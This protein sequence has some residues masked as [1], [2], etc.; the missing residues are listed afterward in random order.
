VDQI[1]TVQP[2]KCR[3]GK[4]QKGLVMEQFKSFH[5]F[6]GDVWHG[7]HPCPGGHGGGIVQVPSGRLGGYSL[8]LDVLV[9]DCGTWLIDPY[10]ERS[11]CAGERIRSPYVADCR[12]PGHVSRDRVGAGVW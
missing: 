3:V 5:G 6:Y 11:N 7:P 4:L 2:L 10:T 1:C 8:G 9:V 12:S